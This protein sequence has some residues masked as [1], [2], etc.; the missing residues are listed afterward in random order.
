MLNLELFHASLDER[1]NEKE[2]KKDVA[3]LSQCLVLISFLC[4][5]NTV[6]SFTVEVMFLVKYDCFW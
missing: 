5:N 2:L 3:F 1:M 4:A 6:S